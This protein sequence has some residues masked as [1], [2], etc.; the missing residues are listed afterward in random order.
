M[1]NYLIVDDFMRSSHKEI[2]N[3]QLLNALYIKYLNGTQVVVVEYE[4][5]QASAQEGKYFRASMQVDL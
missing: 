1:E 4:V 5:P 3:A 2:L